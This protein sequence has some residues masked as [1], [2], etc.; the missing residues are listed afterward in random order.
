MSLHPVPLFYTISLRWIKQAQIM[1][2]HDNAP[3][4]KASTMKRW[5]AKDDME[6]LKWPSQSRDLIFTERWYELKDCL[7]PEPSAECTNAECTNAL[8]SE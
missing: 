2:R 5:F 7:H 4:H 3:V 8:V 6:D 1:F